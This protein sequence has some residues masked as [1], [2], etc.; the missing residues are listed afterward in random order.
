M[1]TAPAIRLFAALEAG[2][3]RVLEGVAMTYGTVERVHGVPSRFMPGVFGDVSGLDL[4]LTFQHIRERPL[5]RTLG[6]GLELTDSPTA[7][8]VRAEL[9]D[10][11]EGRDTYALVQ[12]GVMKGLSVEIFKPAEIVMV[13]GVREYRRAALG[14]MSVVDTA[15]WPGADVA[16]LAEGA[17]TWYPLL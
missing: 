11:Q 6:G 12:R 2:A 5:A 15:A 4:T 1:T 8:S 14:R 7:L 9:A 3:D 10:T 13:D 16:A 17:R